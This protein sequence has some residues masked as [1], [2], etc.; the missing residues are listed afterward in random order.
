VAERLPP[1]SVVAVFSDCL[2]PLEELVSA[3][4][5]FRHARHDL[6]VFQTIDPAE[7][8]FPFEGMT[9]FQGLEGEGAETLDPHSLR[10]AYQAEFADLCRRVSSAAHDMGGDYERLRTDIALDNVLAAFLARR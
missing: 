5:H 8:E 2:G 3:L 6:I 1:R 10:D 9:L 7:E 4:K